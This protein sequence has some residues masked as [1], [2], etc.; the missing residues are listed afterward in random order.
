MRKIHNGYYLT[1]EFTIRYKN[2]M[3]KYDRRIRSDPL[4]YLMLIGCHDNFGAK[5]CPDIKFWKRMYEK[6]N[7]KR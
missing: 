3:R 4:E 6:Q 2:T 5:R 7:A 1:S